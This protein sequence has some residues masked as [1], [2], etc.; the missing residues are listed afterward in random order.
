MERA[1]GADR[2]KN[3]V[4]GAG[5][6][7]TQREAGPRLGPRDGRRVHVERHGSHGKRGAAGDGR[8]VQITDVQALGAHPAADLIPPADGERDGG[9]ANGGVGLGPAGLHA[10]GFVVVVGH[11]GIHDGRPAHHRKALIRR[12][13]SG[14]VNRRGG[15]SGGRGKK[16]TSHSSHSVPLWI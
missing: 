1:A 12:I 2:E 6:D 16:T 8:A 14:M 4:F 9:E 10:Q 5:G 13:E 3:L 15:V 11:G 7:E